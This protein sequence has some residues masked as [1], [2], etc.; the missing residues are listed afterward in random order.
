MIPVL[1]GQVR[2]LVNKFIEPDAL[3]A[4]PHGLTDAEH[5][6]IRA[7]EDKA[8]REGGDHKLAGLMAM[9]ETGKVDT[10]HCGSRAA[11][12]LKAWCDAGGGRS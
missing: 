4:Q 11:A 8:K 1:P 3:I 5:A 7:A 10:I 9:I 2:I 6:A 12:K